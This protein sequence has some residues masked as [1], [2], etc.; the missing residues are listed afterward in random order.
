MF[1][2]GI[3]VARHKHAVVI[4]DEHGKAVPI[5]MPSLLFGSRKRWDSPYNKWL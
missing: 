1:Y 3:D 2:C 5:S 4:L